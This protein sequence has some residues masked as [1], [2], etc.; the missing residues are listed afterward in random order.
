M[1]RRGRSGGRENGGLDRGFDL[2][3]F[4]VGKILDISRGFFV[5]GIKGFT[6]LAL[7]W[8]WEQETWFDRGACQW[9]DVV[10]FD[11]AVIQIDCLTLILRK[12]SIDLLAAARM[13]ESVFGC[14]SPGRRYLQNID[15]AFFTVEHL[16]DLLSIF[17]NS[18]CL[19]L[20]AGSSFSWLWRRSR[21]LVEGI[22]F[23]RIE[24][25]YLIL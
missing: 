6:L 21:Q 20:P 3:F 11:L 25:R 10:G 9:T 2:L 4:R 18:T 5:I 22:V 8:G 13:K 24:L 16:L 23:A 12:F 17:G 15:H 14:R 7:L 19:A 1:N